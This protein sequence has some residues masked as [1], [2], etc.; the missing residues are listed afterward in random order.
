MRSKR[1]TSPLS[2]DFVIVGGGSAGSVLAS[3]LSADPG[4]TR[5]RARGRTAGLLVGRV[6]PHAGGADAPERQPLLRL[7]VRE[8]A[9]AVHGRSAGTPHTGQGARRLVEHQRD[10][11][12]ARQPPRFRALGSRTR[13]GQLELCP[14]PSLLQDDGDL[15]RRCR[16]LSRRRRTARSRAWVGDEPSLQRL[17]RG[18]STGRLL[19]DRRRQRVPPGGLRPIRPEPPPRP[20]AQR[21]PGLPPSGDGSPEP[22][23]GHTSKRDGHSLPAAT[24]H[25][26]R[27]PNVARRAAHGGGRGGDPLRRRLQLAA[28]AP[29]VGRRGWRP[30]PRRRRAG[31]PPSAWRRRQ[32]AGPPRGVRP[33]RGEPASIAQPAARLV[34]ASVDRPAVDLPPADRE[35]RTTSRRAGSCAATT[36]SPTRT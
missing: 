29:G 25:R 18:R 32:P 11:L 15:S 21:R 8:R 7:E 16:R 4:D 26:C 27:V 22:R 28:A 5:A 35:R 12:P 33:A 24:R 3:R 30:P 14:L 23:R 10:D 20:A 1:R 34:P 17:L 9:R 36:T 13:N 31:C 2:Y 19:V 6:D